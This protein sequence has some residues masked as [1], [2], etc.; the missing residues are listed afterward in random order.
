MLDAQTPNSP[1]WW[2]VRLGSKLQDESHRFN[3]LEAYWRG[4][5]A[6]PFGNRKMREAYRRLQ[7]QARSNYAALVS[8]TVLERL[9]VAG[10]RNGSTGTDTQDKEAWS[11]W[12]ANH[13]DADSLLVHRAAVNLSRSY[14]IVGRTEDG[15]PLVTGEDPR[16]VIHESDPED[17]RKVRA[18]LKV[19]WDD[20]ESHFVAVVY[21]P[22]EVHYYES[23]PKI[24][25]DCATLWKPA[26]WVATGEDIVDFGGDVPVVPFVNRPDLGGDGLGEFEDVTD[27]LDRIATTTLD[28]LVITAMQAYRQRYATGIDPTD[29]DGNI[30]KTFDPG[31]DLLWIAD[32]E[33][34]KFGE[35]GV[36]DVSAVL[37]AVES[38]VQHLAAITRT[39]PHYLLSTTTNVSGDALAA[40][41]SGLVSK[42]IERSVEFGEAWE[43]VYRL[44]GYITGQDIAEDAEVIWIDPQFRTLTELASAAVQLMSAGVPWRSRMRK[45]GYTPPEID[46]MEAE[47]A[48][49]AMLSAALAP[50]SLAE[51]GQIG[52]RGV[53][54]NGAVPAEQGT[55]AADSKARPADAGRPQQPI[56]P[57][58]PP[59]Q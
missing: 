51:G 16:Q 46:R 35:F 58:A 15:K 24:K 9:K 50:L 31:A 55:P 49:D 39:P 54:F 33:N 26:N 18:A 1:D 56:S 59:T 47:R 10:F 40:A 25:Q 53:A 29:E 52:S 44:A 17:R 32:D 23:V 37:K 21:L 8:E 6:V 28:R 2:L 57:A 38:D 20:V 27:V 3:A 43:Q 41:E 45:L 34:V 4:E 48:H 19:Y 13:M 22:G 5:P 36:T 11:W 42:T 30:Q 7:K 12:Q 14:V